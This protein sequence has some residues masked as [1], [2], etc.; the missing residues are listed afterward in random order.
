MMPRSNYQKVK[1]LY[2]AKIFSEKTD[3]NHG[4]STQELIQALAQYDIAADRKT[5]YQD[6]EELRQFGMDI[7]SD[8]QGKM[9]YYKLVSRD[10]ELPELKLLVDSVQ[11]ARF[12][13]ESKSRS[14]VKKL[15]SLVSVYDA[16]QLHRQVILSG[17]IKTGNENIFYSVDTIHAA[18]NT[19]VQ[20]TFQYFRWNLKKEMELRH[21]GAWYHVSPWALIWDDEWYYL[22][23]YDHDNAEIRH[24]R[25]DKMIHLELT[26]LPREGEDAM[27]EANLPQYSNSLFGMFTGEPQ[28]VTIVCENKLIGAIIDRFGT[29]AHIRKLDDTHFQAV[30]HVMA[31]QPFLGWVF[32]L[33]GGAKITAP[34]PLVEAMREETKRLMEQYL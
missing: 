21:D 33:G 3:E 23:G 29:E 27:K 30:V 34:E 5:I 18:I 7:I 32:S 10:F 19:N 16:K 31:S 8:H 17:R 20:I 6:L 22:V 2:L 9:Y 25:V 15:E 28:D 24:Y 13:T 11:A 26:D 1:L 4:L 12:V 14:L